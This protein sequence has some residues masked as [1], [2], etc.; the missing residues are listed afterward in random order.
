MRVCYRQQRKVDSQPCGCLLPCPRRSL[1]L[2]GV[3]YWVVSHGVIQVVPETPQQVLFVVLCLFL[4]HVYM[5]LHLSLYLPLYFFLFL[6]LF[7][8]L[9]FPDPLFFF[10]L[11]FLFTPVFLLLLCLSVYTAPFPLGHVSVFSS[12]TTTTTATLSKEG[13]AYHRIFGIS[14]KLWTYQNLSHCS[15]LYHNQA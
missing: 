3:A 11:H 14:L 7:P 10:C 9:F 5:S 6:S 1:A 8:S 4:I 12:T 15:G 2:A 13:S